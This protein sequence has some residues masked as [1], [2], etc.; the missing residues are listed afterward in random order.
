MHFDGNFTVFYM[1][2]ISLGFWTLP[3]FLHFLK[4]SRIAAEHIFWTFKGIFRKRVAMLSKKGILWLS[5][6]RWKQQSHGSRLPHRGLCESRKPEKKCKLNLHLEFKMFQIFGF[7]HASKITVFGAKIQ[8]L[9]TK[10]KWRK[11][12]IQFGT[13]FGAKINFFSYENWKFN[14]NLRKKLQEN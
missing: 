7:P 1:N 10:K 3:T 14:F 2:L 9:L 8:T 12:Q 5:G 4:K 6:L 13:I 11:Y